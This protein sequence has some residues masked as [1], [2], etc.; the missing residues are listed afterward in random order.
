[1]VAFFDFIGFLMAVIVGGFIL[2]LII[3]FIAYV[4]YA[5]YEKLR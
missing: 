1:M 4:V 2:S 5:T 3:G